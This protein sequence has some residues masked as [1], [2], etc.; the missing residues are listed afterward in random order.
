MTDSDR[1]TD[2]DRESSII[3]AFVHLSD[4]LVDD[5]DV[6]EFLHFLTE[7]CIDLVPVDEAAVMLA[8]PSGNMQAVASSSERSRLLE[9]FEL[10]NRDG[11]C[12]DAYRSGTVVRSAEL[13]SERDRWPTFAGRAIDDGFRAVHSIPLRLRDE[14]I[15]A[16]NLMRVQPGHLSDS[17]A[18]LVQA[19]SD[20]ATI[21]VL[22]ERYVSRSASVASGLQIALTSRIRIEQAKGI[23]SERSNISVDDAFDLLR[24]YARGRSQRL[25]EVAAR[26]VERSLDITADTPPAT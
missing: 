8:A 13:S 15:G 14:I 11:P 10:Q 25:S 21:G 6:I 7:C 12:L 26:V 2:V 4:T 23:I 20:I 17:D 19:L 18:R 16:L 22:Q 3:D 1:T 5:Y 24:S 9:L